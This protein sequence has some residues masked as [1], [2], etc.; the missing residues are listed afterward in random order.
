MS[1][2]ERDGAGHTA[3]P[4]ARHD[5]GPNPAPDQSVDLVWGIG[6]VERQP[7]DK[8]NWSFNWKWRLSRVA[9]A[10][11]RPT[12]TA[13]EEN[14]HA[15]VV[16]EDGKPRFVIDGPSPPSDALV[17]VLEELKPA[18]INALISPLG[19]WSNLHNDPEDDPDPPYLF[20]STLADI[21]LA[22]PAL[23][24]LTAPSPSGGGV[25]VLGEVKGA[26]EQL[27]READT[28]PTRTHY[29]RGVARGICKATSAIEDAL[30]K[31]SPGDLGRLGGADAAT[32]G[33]S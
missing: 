31:L 6:I 3:G 27:E 30:S 22:L 32:D 33:V 13:G 20:A 7:S 15:R 23:A 2:S 14:R 10:I 1:G 17:G 18:L 5:G 28:L 24:Q 25:D 16:I 12:P 29:E 21:V 8:V 26:L 9:A 19:R 4:W 11:A